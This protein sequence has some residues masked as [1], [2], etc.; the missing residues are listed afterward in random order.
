MLKNFFAPTSKFWKPRSPGNAWA[1]G[2][3][4]NAESK[5]P[6]IPYSW[7]GNTQGNTSPR[8][9]TGAV[10]SHNG[11]YRAAHLAHAKAVRFVVCAP[12]ASK[13]SARD[14]ELLGG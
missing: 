8:M 10:F 14:G 1:G 6:G 4:L 13:I 9:E 7:Q 5:N 11:Q 2:E 3:A 12:V